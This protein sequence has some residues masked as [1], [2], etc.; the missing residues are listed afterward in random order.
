MELETMNT[1][2]KIMIVEDYTP[3]RSVLSFMLSHAGYTALET[4]DAASA[5]DEA[6]RQ[7]PDLV[8][9]DRQLPDMDGL[10]LLQHWRRE[11]NTAG[12][13]VIMVSGRADDEDR[14]AGFRAGADDYVVKPFHR[15]ELLARVEAVLR[16]A[17]P[18]PREADR[19]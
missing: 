11:E 2:H 8:L 3:L 19:E 9:L 5:M 6:G 18:A 12:M 13:P 17:A 16:R 7:P 15:A 1:R 10:K 4:A 14:V